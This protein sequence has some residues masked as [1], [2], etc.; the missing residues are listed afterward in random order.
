MNT[1]QEIN[2]KLHELAADG[3]WLNVH[4]RAGSIE[5]K[6]SGVLRPFEGGLW[7]VTDEMPHLM[8]R[9]NWFTVFAVEDVAAIGLGLKLSGAGLI[10][11]IYLSP[12]SHDRATLR[13]RALANEEQ[14]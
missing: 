14:A 12:I 10:N 1:P 11:T 2:A 4:L 7:H 13:A 3:R 8:E 6:G 5:L 9:H